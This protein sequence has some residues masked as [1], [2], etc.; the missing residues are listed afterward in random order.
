VLHTKYKGNGVK[1]FKEGGQYQL[2]ISSTL[3]RWTLKVQQLQPEEAELY[4]PK[5]PQ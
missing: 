2:R 3:A 1:L 4:T 5:T